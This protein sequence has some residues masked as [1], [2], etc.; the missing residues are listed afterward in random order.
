M[1]DMLSHTRNSA[2]G[3]GEKYGA[4]AGMTWDWFTVNINS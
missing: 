4:V 3:L 2:L 1:S